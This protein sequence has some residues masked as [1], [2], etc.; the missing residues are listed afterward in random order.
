MKQIL[1]P[2]IIIAVLAPR[3]LGGKT[4]DIVEFTR[5]ADHIFVAKVIRKSG[6]WLSDGRF[7]YSTFEIEVFESIKGNL[8]GR[9]VVHQPGGYL[10]GVFYR[11]DKASR[12][13]VADLE[14]VDSDLIRPGRTYVFAT[15][16]SVRNP[17]LKLLSGHPVD[18]T[19]I[20][21]D[22]KADAATIARAAADHPQVAEFKTICQLERLNPK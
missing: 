9:I 5:R 21:N 4:P 19:L 3:V 12:K 7:P 20:T 18:C 6:E 13:Y 8:P 14:R 17:T 11:F 2:L 22:S 1:I 10:Q 15:S 16:P